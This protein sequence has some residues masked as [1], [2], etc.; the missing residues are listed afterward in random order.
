MRYV[1]IAFTRSRPMKLVFTA[2]VPLL[3]AAC[4]SPQFAESTNP[5]AASFTIRTTALD[6]YDI[7]VV[8]YAGD[9]YLES[10]G[11]IVTLLNSKAIGYAPSKTVRVNP[12]SPFRFTVRSGPQELTGTKT[13]PTVCMT[14]TSFLPE[15]GAVYVATYELLPDGCNTWVM[16]DIG[17]GRMIAEP[18][19]R[20]HASCLDPNLG[21]GQF[22]S[23]CREGF[24]FR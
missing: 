16:R 21:M 15:A 11:A 1:E 13:K 7:A 6:R 17:G 9:E 23:A 14:H 20:K 19:A 4:A 10:K 12:G 22:A 8:S 24:T 2:V 3:L 18:T 5:A